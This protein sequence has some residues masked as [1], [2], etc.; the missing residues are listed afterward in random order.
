MNIF[1]LD[2]L[3]RLHDKFPNKLIYYPENKREPLVLKVKVITKADYVLEVWSP[4]SFGYGSGYYLHG[5]LLTMYK[6]IVHENFYTTHETV[7]NNRL[8]LCLNSL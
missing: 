4:I 6:E 3:I 1:K 7:P 8:N 2:Q 5:D